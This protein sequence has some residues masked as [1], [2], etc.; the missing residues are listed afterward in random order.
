[1]HTRAAAVLGSGLDHVTFF[2]CALTRS[3]PVYDL[4]TALHVVASQRCR[5]MQIL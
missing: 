2:Q 1:M 3:L 5:T 4:T